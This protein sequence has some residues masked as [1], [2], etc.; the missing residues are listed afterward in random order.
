[1]IQD[2]PDRLTCFPDGIPIRGDWVLS[3]RGGAVAFEPWREH[4]VTVM[5]LVRVGA[6]TIFLGAAGASSFG[7]SQQLRCLPED[8]LRFGAFTAL[9]LAQWVLNHRYCGRCG[10]LNVRCG[11][12]LVCS[13]C[14]CEQ[15]PVIAPAVILGLVHEG[16]LLI[17]HYANRPY[18][19]PALVAGYCEVGE[20]LEDTCRR[21][22]LEETGLQIT[23]DFR[24]FASQPWGLSGSVLMGFFAE[25]TSQEVSLNDGELADAVWTRPDAL[26]PPPDAVGTLSLTATMIEAF[27]V[28]WLGTK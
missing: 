26:P 7:S 12:R 13:V 18:R 17:T 19:G 2:V 27:R 6:Q 14:G 10:G 25:V 9:H 8:A 5:P 4:M 28:G 23:G 16:R 1:M 24:Y 22:A 15:Y 20:T 21:E 3:C 11:A